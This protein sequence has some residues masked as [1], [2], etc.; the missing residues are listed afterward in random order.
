[1][2]KT[3]LTLVIIGAI[4]WLFVGLF[5]L[6]AVAAIFGGQASMVSRSIY[7]IVGLAGLYCIGLL[8]TDNR[9]RGSR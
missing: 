1:M 9:V 6:D 8:F 3:A 4:N 7:V 5:Q 2:S